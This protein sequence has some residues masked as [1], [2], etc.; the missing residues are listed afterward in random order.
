MSMVRQQ[1]VRLQS[2]TSRVMKMRDVCAFTR[3]LNTVIKYS[4]EIIAGVIYVVR[5]FLQSFV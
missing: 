1:A 4:K 5:I 2:R 3:N